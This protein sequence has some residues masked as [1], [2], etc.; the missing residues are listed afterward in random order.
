MTERP[1]RR[2]R[3]PASRVGILGAS[4]AGFGALLTA[5]PLHAGAQATT[6]AAQP[7]ATVTP[8]S[9]PRPVVVRVIRR[10]HVVAPDAP[11]P[12][13]EVPHAPVAA[14][15]PTPPLAPAPAP[16]TTTHGSR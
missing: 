4:V 11:T 15:A 9:T 2:R 7:L 8:S 10:W 3:A 16:D 5:L 1:R 13:A 12:I 6:A 14:S